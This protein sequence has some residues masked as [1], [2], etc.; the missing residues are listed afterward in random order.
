MMHRLLTLCLLILATLTLPYQTW[1]QGTYRTGYIVQLNNDTLRGELQLRSA[2]RSGQLCRFRATATATTID[3]QPTQLRAY[4]LDGIAAYRAQLVPKS[5]AEAAAVSFVKLLVTGR[6]NL[7]AYQDR[8]DEVHF[9]LAMGT[10]SL[11]ELRK[12]RVQK[13]VDNQEYFEEQTPFRSVLAKA[14]SDCPAVQYLLPQLPLASSD[15]TK[16]VTRYNACLG[17]PPTTQTMVPR[18][19]SR[20]S[21]GIAGG[22]DATKVDFSQV[23]TRVRDGSFTG[24]S[25]VA[26]FFVDFVSPAFNRNMAF[27]LDMLYEKM[28]YADAYVAR[29]VSTVEERAQTSFD[30]SYLKLPL[31]V[32]YHFNTGRFRPF[33]QAG[34]SMSFLLSHDSHLRSEYTSASG[35]PVV[36]EYGSVFDELFARTDYGLLVGAGLATPGVA[37]HAISVE[38][39]GERGSG[40][41]SEGV[42]SPILHLGALLSINLTK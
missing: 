36:T 30:V 38:V 21:V 6:A 9:Y 10:D 31:Q 39:R 17:G 12:F 1:A 16:L 27:R 14:F 28:H 2:I 40:F 22:V 4:G 41:L 11:Q 42:S 25:P 32:R 23:L 20:L 7:Y 15:L 18:Q 34:G 8:E 3:Y 33:L 24:T 19:H 26:G 5:K 13:I 35:H 29:N 37:G